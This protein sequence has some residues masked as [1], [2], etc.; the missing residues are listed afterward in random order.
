[1]IH[2]TP[3]RISRRTRNLLLAGALAALLLIMWAAPSVP[4][5]AI[6]GF[7][8]AII[9]SF[10]V[11]A[12]SQI[13][14]R[15]LAIL[16]SFLSLAGLVVFAIAVLVPILIEQLSAL[17]AATPAIAGE[18]DRML[19][20]L[21]MMLA[22]RNL[23]PGTPEDFIS[24]LGEDLFNR[25]QA[26]AERALGGL[27]GFVSG[28]ISIGIAL[29]GML[30]VAA[31]LL[32]DVRRIKAAYLLAVPSRYRRDA[33]ELWDSFGFSLSRYLSGLAFVLI[34]QGVL[35]AIALA[36]LGVPYA[37][38]L[39]A[40]VSITAI[41][42]YLGAWLGA[43]PAV[44][45]AFFVSPLT[46]VLTAIVFFAIQQIESNLLTPRIQGVAVRVHPIIILLAVIAG[47]EIAGLLG[48]VLAVPTVAVLRVLFDF[49]RVRITTE[50]N[51]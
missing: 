45:V 26:L 2:P 18:A 5:I 11:R 9:I 19:R 51:Y 41:I 24:N 36:I 4:I 8:L 6:G 31:Y 32:I 42:P 34:A 50:E 48:V 40:W 39:G 14:P 1:M 15:G 49:F 44:I 43:I 20:S 37:I 30:F 22:D 46:A 3:I 23:L 29:F 28:V 13:M 12:L 17:I 38:L 10:P 47:G 33:R 7:A 35:S 21:V 27:V 25:A 16:V